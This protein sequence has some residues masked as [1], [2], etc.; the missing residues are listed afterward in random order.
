MDLVIRLEPVGGVSPALLAER[1][2]LLVPGI[3]IASIGARFAVEIFVNTEDSDEERLNLAAI[4]NNK[5]TGV[6]MVLTGPSLDV[7]TARML[8]KELSMLVWSARGVEEAWLQLGGR[9]IELTD[10]RPED[11][12][13]ERFA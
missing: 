2:R 7:M 13:S 4:E 12:V 11:I 6:A 8:L 3:T 1:L 5:A 10:A 9:R